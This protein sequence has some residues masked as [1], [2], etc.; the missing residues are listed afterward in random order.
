MKT[1]RAKSPCDYDYRLCVYLNID[2]LLV[3]MFC[4]TWV[5]TMFDKGITIAKSNALRCYL[6]VLQRQL[7]VW[8]NGHIEAQTKLLPTSWH[9]Q[10]HFLELN[11]LI[12]I[13]I[14]MKFVPNRLINNIALL[15]P[16]RRQAIIW[17]NDG[18]FTDA[19]MRHC[20]WVKVKAWWYLI[21]ETIESLYFTNSKV[22][23]NH[24]LL[25]WYRKTWASIH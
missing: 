5:Q 9:F 13:Q 22:N 20:Q 15:S 1:M 18:Y 21:Q 16:G 2:Q 24:R 4:F 12:S 10:M 7:L 14:S 23:W 8:S 3:K 11:I 25:D 6:S 19:H 17:I